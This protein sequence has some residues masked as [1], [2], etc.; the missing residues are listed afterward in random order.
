M[1]TPALYT[2]GHGTL[3]EPDM[4]DL[5]H[6]AGIAA[7][8]DIRTA[9]GSRRHPQFGRDRLS[10]WLPAGG[11]SYRW[12]KELGGFRRARDDSVN[13]ALRHPSFRGYADYMRTAP[14]ADALDRLLAEAAAAPVAAMCSET[15]WWRCHRR[16]VSDFVVLARGGQVRPLMHDGRLSEHRVTDGARRADD[17]LLIYDVGVTPPLDLPDS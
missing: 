11:V 4:L 12:E 10:E 7:V 1:A 17:G 15:V 8:V 16:L 3:P 14:F 5:L 9:P 13:I 2:V 6:G